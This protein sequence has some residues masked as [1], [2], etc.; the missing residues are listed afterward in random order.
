MVQRFRAVFRVGGYEFKPPAQNF[1][2]FSEIFVG[3]FLSR[4]YPIQV[5]LWKLYTRN[6]PK[7]LTK[8]VLAGA[9]F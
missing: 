3:I 8:Y 9:S 6:L 2:E 5:K 7:L 4:S 1:D